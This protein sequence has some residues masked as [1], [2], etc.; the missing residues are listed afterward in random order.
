MGFEWS[1]LAPEILIRLDRSTRGTLGAQLQ[2]ELRDA[3]RSG[4]LAAGERL[5]STR[6]LAREL[7]VSRGLAQE[8]YE[9]LV[10]EGY[11]LARPGAGTVVAG[12]GSARPHASRRPPA[13]T[14]LVDF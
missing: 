7:G 14:L 13:A 3:V 10:A 2:Q 5:P 9:Q 4:R 6:T 12:A 11:L 8:C 1:G